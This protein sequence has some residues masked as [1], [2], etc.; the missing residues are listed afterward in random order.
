M[1]ETGETLEQ[2]IARLHDPKWLKEPGHVYQVWEDGEVTLQKSGDLLWQRNLHMMEFGIPG[3]DFTMPMKSHSG[4]SYAVVASGEEA[5]YLR[6]L[7][8]ARWR[9]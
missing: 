1:G 7:M 2:A 4:H 5:E 6:G 9:A 8:R 3:V